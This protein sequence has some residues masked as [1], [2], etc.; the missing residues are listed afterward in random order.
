MPT[1]PR[2]RARG[3]SSTSSP[4]RVSCR[5]ISRISLHSA[6]ARHGQRGDTLAA[7]HEADALTGTRLHVHA[8]GGEFQRALEALADGGPVGVDGRLL[9]DDR[10]V[11]V[12]DLE[13]APGHDPDDELQQ[14]DR[15]GVA[16][17]LL[18]GGKVLADV[19]QSRRPE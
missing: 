8:P 15:V 14:L 4:L 19:A 5:R 17:A 3:R 16:P 18:A 13:A 11:D 6:Q 7:P 10:A 1:R 2:P 9:H 12:Y